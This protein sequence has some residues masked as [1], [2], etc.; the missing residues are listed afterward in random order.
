MPKA[1]QMTL[2]VKYKNARGPAYEI[3]RVAKTKVGADA[4][5]FLATDIRCPRVES[6]RS[7]QEKCDPNKRNGNCHVA[8]QEIPNSD[9]ESYG[10]WNDAKD[11]LIF[12]RSAKFTFETSRDGAVDGG[13]HSSQCRRGDKTCDG[14]NVLIGTESFFGKESSKENRRNE[15]EKRHEKIVGIAPKSATDDVRH[16]YF[17]KMTEF[18]DDR[19]NSAYEPV[20][21]FPHEGILYI[22]FDFRQRW[23]PFLQNK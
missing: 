14:K 2:C 18:G 20:F 19:P 1:T 9:A 12:C 13:I 6:I 7:R 4:E 5:K 23:R 21:D 11:D 15:T 3:K 8:V 22:S 17:E 16:V 10:R